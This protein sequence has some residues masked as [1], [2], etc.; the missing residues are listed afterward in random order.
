MPVLRPAALLLLTIAC[1][2]G[3]TPKTAPDPES[4]DQAR[5]RIDNRASLDMDIYVVRSENQSIRLGFV[6]G[7][8]AATFALPATVTVGTTFITFEARPVR[9]SGQTVTSE[10]FGVHTGEEIAWSIPP[11]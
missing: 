3:S 1:S 9:R 8:E 5:V 6:A 7:G 2:S 4:V 11:Q 10:P